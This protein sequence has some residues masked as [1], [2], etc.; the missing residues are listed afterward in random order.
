MWGPRRFLRGQTAFSKPGN[1]GM[2]WLQGRLNSQ[3]HAFRRVNPS[4]NMTSLKRRYML[5]ASLRVGQLPPGMAGADSAQAQIPGLIRDLARQVS[6]AGGLNLRAQGDLITALFTRSVSAASAAVLM[7]EELARQQALVAAAGHPHALAWPRLRVAITAGAVAEVGGDCFGDP[8]GQAARLLE[9]AQ[10]GESLITQPV[11]EDLPWELLPRFESC[12]AARLSPGQPPVPLHRLIREP[13]A[14]AFT[15]QPAPAVVPE[16]APLEVVVPPPPPPP[17][18]PPLGVV[19]SWHGKDL[20]FERRHMPVLI[21]RAPECGL[22]ID[23]GRVSRQHA[24]I[25]LIDGDLRLTDTSS[26]GTF[27]RFAH[28]SRTHA[29]RRSSC[30]LLGRGDIGLGGPPGDKRVATV[31]F[32]VQE[33]AALPDPPAVNS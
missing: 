27:I 17:P 6:T 12:A 13:I 3:R 8:V 19:L 33:A 25:D 4:G 2:A 23:H 10:D 22:G 31:A 26:N 21:G 7:I 20:L 1:A 24:R 9:H 16:P 5:F 15:P 14:Q 18:P 32:V 29:L 28:N 30:P 11:F